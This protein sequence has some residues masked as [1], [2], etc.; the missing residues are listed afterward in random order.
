MLTGATE[1]TGVTGMTVMKRIC[2][3]TG[4]TGVTEMTRVTGMSRTLG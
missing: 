2:Q 1:M 3:R 4:I